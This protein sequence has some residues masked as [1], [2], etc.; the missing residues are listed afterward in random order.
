MPSQD[1][2]FNRLAHRELVVNDTTSAHSVNVFKQIER[3]ILLY[4][5]SFFLAKPAHRPN[6]YRTISTHISL[7]VWPLTRFS[8]C[9]AQEWLH[10]EQ[11]MSRHPAAQFTGILPSSGT[12]LQRGSWTS[13]RQCQSGRGPSPLLP[14]QALPSLHQPVFPECGVPNS[15]VH[16]CFQALL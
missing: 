5:F 13:P 1:H 12:V 15:S 4:I 16:Y 9:T 8:L 10:L 7:F 14:R 3:Y 2:R 6:I 11:T